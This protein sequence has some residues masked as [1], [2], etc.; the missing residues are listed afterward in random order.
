MTKEEKQKL[1]DR[2]WVAYFNIKKD[3]WQTEPYPRNY[4]LGGMMHIDYNDNALTIYKPTRDAA[5]KERDRRNEI[6]KLGLSQSNAAYE[7]AF[8]ATPEEIGEAAVAMALNKEKGAIFCCE[9][10]KNKLR[11]YLLEKASDIDVESDEIEEIRNN[12]FILDDIKKIFE[13]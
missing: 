10:L 1:K 2:I 5:R 7:K 12:I 9:F 11:E 6:I 3:R 4:H 13:K 8:H